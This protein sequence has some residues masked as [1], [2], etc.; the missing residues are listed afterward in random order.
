MDSYISFTLVNDCHVHH[1]TSSEV[2]SLEEDR[3]EK[4]R[5]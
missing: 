5:Q 2:F 3:S 1:S 4:D